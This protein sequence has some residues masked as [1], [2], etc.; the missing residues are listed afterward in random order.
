[1]NEVQENKADTAERTVSERHVEAVRQQGGVF[2]EAAR[3]TR[4]P[5]LVTI[6]KPYHLCDLTDDL[7]R[8]S[9]ALMEDALFSPIDAGAAFIM[10]IEWRSMSGH[11][12][13]TGEILALEG[14][15]GGGE[16][17]YSAAQRP[18]SSCGRSTVV[19]SGLRWKA[20]QSSS[21]PTTDTSNGICFPM[22]R[23]AS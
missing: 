20:I 22:S 9:G 14:L 10:P 12:S 6:S 3:R 11:S 8:G 2:V 21:Y 23:R 5:M 7:R 13:C 4:M 15:L 16:R 1:M 18:I 17:R 19:N